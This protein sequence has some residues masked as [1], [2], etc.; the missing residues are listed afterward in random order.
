VRAYLS[1][2]CENDRQVL[3]NLNLNILK[4]KFVTI[5]GKSGCGKSTLSRLLSG[6]EKPTD[7]QIIMGEKPLMSLNHQAC[8]MLQDGRLLPWKRILENMELG[9][10]SNHHEEAIVV[11]RNIGL[12]N[13]IYDWPS[14]P[15]GEQKQRVV[16]ERTL[17][18]KPSLLL[19]DEPLRALD[20]SLGSRRKV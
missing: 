6:L 15:L 3:N 12:E 18:H 2:R 14:K 10:K 1:W 13:R 20:A 11:L 9:L 7:G 8:M 16:L 19:L 17:I 4:E 5:A